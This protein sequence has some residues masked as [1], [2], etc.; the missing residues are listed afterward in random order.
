MR[1]V[2]RSRYFA[3]AEEYQRAAGSPMVTDG[4]RS[5]VLPEVNAS[6]NIQDV[7][8]TVTAFADLLKRFGAEGEL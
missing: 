7:D 1:E 8:R 6:Q 3:D 2:L 4:F 5:H